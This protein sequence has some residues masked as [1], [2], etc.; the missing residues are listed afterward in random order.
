MIKGEIVYLVFHNMRVIFKYFLYCLLLSTGG[1]I[2]A[3]N[4]NVFMR[5][6][7]SYNQEDGLPGP[8]VYCG[9]QDEQGFLWFGTRAGI[10]RYDGVNFKLIKHNRD[11][12]S[13]W[14]IENLVCDNEG[15]LLISYTNPATTNSLRKR[16]VLNTG[17]FEIMKFTDY[18]KQLPFPDSLI[19]AVFKGY[20]NKL[21]F[22]VNLPDKFWSYSVKTGFEKRYQQNKAFRNFNIGSRNMNHIFEGPDFLFINWLS[23]HT[24]MLNKDTMVKLPGIEHHSIASQ[25]NGC[26][27]YK[28]DSVN[29]K[30][31]KAFYFDKSGTL[32]PFPFFKNNDLLYEG[33]HLSK[34]VNC[35]NDNTCVFQT[36]NGETVYYDRELGL[37]PVFDQSSTN[38]SQA[39]L[40]HYF[41]DR[42]GV[43]WLCTSKGLSK[44]ILG[45]KRFTNHFNIGANFKTNNNSVRGI[46]ANKNLFCANLF[47]MIVVQKGRDTLL[48]P[49]HNNYGLLYSDTGLWLGS[50]ELR[51][52][53][54]KTKQ[55]NIIAQSQ[56]N[57]IWSLFPL[58]KNRLLLGCTG[59]LDE[60]T[61]ATKTIKSLFNPKFPKPFFV[62]K[63]YNTPSN[64][65]W[66]I[67]D[68]GIFV[69][70]QEGVIVDYYGYKSNT[71]KHQLPFPSIRDVYADKQGIYWV[72]TNGQ[73]LCRWNRTTHTFKFLGIE[74]G[75]LSNVIYGIQED[76][77]DNLWLSTD[78][79]LVKFNKETGFIKTYTEKD[80][81]GS[82]EF[83]R[84]SQFKDA[85]GRIYFG[86]MNGVTSFDPREFAKDTSSINFD[87]RI[88]SMLWYNKAKGEEENVLP[89][90]MKRG[91]LA[92]EP[93]IDYVT[94]S[95]ALL[96]FGLG[97]PHYAYKIEGLDKQW[98]SIRENYVRLSNL[99][100]GSFKLWIKAQ[101]SSGYWNNSMICVPLIVEPPFYKTWWF[102]LLLFLGAV[103]IIGGIIYLRLRQRINQLQR[104][105]DLRV[106]LASDLHDEVGGLLNKSAMQ[107]ELAKSKVNQE[108][109]PILDKIA[110]N[111]RQAMSSMRDIMWNLDARNDN[112]TNLFDR[113]REYA[114]MMLTE[115]YDYELEIN[116]LENK[117]ILPE[118]RQSVYL[119]YKEAVNNII[120]H[121]RGG[122]V[123]IRLFYQHNHLH[124]VIY[125]ES[126]FVENEFSTGQGLRNMRM[127]AERVKGTFELRFEKGVEISVTIP[128]KS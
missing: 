67:A 32:S 34:F 15:A 100:Y 127:R 37:T 52:H 25:Q 118:V 47:D 125:N 107:S 75:F 110:E 114:Q 88:S 71:P 51:Y 9:V 42:S 36:E 40:N 19:T 90:F 17:N 39:V 109:R 70:N 22:L 111:C 27:V 26:L 82:N 16:F 87:F 106:K 97:S 35:D 4:Q 29:R 53:D 85:A 115:Q 56:S 84:S 14:R 99:P 126:T 108:V 12:L 113:I 38:S 103:A 31:G 54:F 120:K 92:I 123:S 124:L 55:T 78:Y 62:Y 41:K 122:R 58:S 101:T 119:I 3:Q 98:N 77:F 49:K 94:L 21:G 121:T 69:L 128:V 57:E 102:V 11:E 74:N 65:L 46:Y 76:D 24:V 18:F 63:I 83:N 66:A 7:Q 1:H 50:F 10:V 28:F 61:I 59:G 48:I 105:N 6:A 91:E 81:I 20:N 5:S 13:G 104:M 117:V 93:N 44:L 68:N 96:D 2:L 112:I 8:E 23:W 89:D 79:G 30:I 80:G 116:G 64:E 86:G 43:Y 33:N 60:Y 95:F 72:A 45:K 73:G